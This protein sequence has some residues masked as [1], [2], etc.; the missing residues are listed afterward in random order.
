ME[1]LKTTFNFR[2]TTFRSF[3]LVLLRIYG[4]LFA[5]IEVLHAERA[6]QEG[7][8][9]YAA[10]HLSNNDAV[11][12]Q[13]VIPRTMCYMGKAELFKNP[14]FAWVLNKLGAFP[15]ERGKFDRQAMLDAKWVLQSGFALMMFPEGTRMFGKGL[16]EAHTGTAHLAMRNDCTIVPVALTGADKILKNGLRKAKVRVVFCEPIRPQKDETA[17]QLTERLMHAIAAELPEP[18]RGFYA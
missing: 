10:N 2:E 11:L 8:V 3:V 14:V 13:V 16:A 5:D 6:K 1:K 9:M 12:L 4:W 7:A 17:G 18:L 15:I